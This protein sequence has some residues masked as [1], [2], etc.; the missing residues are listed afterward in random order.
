MDSQWIELTITYAELRLDHLEGR[1]VTD[2][3]CPAYV[4]RLACIASESSPEVVTTP[5]AVDKHYWLLAR[6]ESHVAEWDQAYEGLTVRKVKI[7]S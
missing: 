3:N 4:K 5:S 2:V 1:D 6:L 7:S